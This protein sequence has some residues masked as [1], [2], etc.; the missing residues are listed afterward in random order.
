[1]REPPPLRI[2]PTLSSQGS[3]PALGSPRRSPP[4]GTVPCRS[5]AASLAA[6]PTS[7]VPDTANAGP[8]IFYII[9]AIVA[10]FCAIA[11]GLGPLVF[12]LGGLALGVVGFRARRPR[13][14]GLPLAI[15]GLGEAV[16]AIAGWRATTVIEVAVILF[17]VLVAVRLAGHRSGDRGQLSAWRPPGPGARR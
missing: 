1:V 9:S 12:A 15:A 13:W 8:V 11:L 7:I 10:L 14:W 6:P 4:D 5:P 16:G 2:G 17:L 3:A